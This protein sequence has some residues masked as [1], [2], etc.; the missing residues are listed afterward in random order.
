LSD[1]G[2]S[3]GEPTR[4]EKTKAGLQGVL[5]TVQPTQDK[6][7]AIR[8]DIPLS[9]QIKGTMFEVKPPDEPTLFDEKTE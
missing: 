1:K 8:S 3:K 4:Y 9:E 2:K 5:L 7:G 6:L